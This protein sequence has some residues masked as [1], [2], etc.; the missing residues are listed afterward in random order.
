MEPDDDFRRFFDGQ[1][2]NLRRLGYLLTRSGEQAEELAQD[3]MVR[4]Y[5][6]WSR[7]ADQDQACGYARAI[8]VNRH[9]SLLRRALVAARHR[10]GDAQ[11]QAPA[12]LPGPEL[13]LVVWAALG[14]L[15]D[16][17][18]TV[19]VLRFY[20]DLSEA[21]VARLVHM[22]PGTVKSHTRRGLARLRRELAQLDTDDAEH[23]EV[24]S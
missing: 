8:L 10:G 16:A 23:T 18:R 20:E 6:A 14:R 7:I 17:Q 2:G 9:R 5:S 22:P 24:S 19:L 11:V 12:S 1:F 4:T 15:S 21:E 13:H 3:T